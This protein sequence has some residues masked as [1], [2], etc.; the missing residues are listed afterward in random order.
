MKVVKI[1]LDKQTYQVDLKK[2]E[3]AINSN[4][5]C[6]VG[7]MPNFPHGVFDD[8]EGLSKLA[9]KYKVPLHVDACLGG[10]LVCFMKSA[11]ISIPKFDFNLPGVTSI[12]A[13]L[14][15]YGLCPKGISL[16]LYS[17]KEYR[18]HQ[19]YFYPHFMGGLYPTPS[20]EG[21]RT[22]AFIA[23]AYAVMVHVGKDAYINQAKVIHKAI[24]EIKNYANKNFKDIR[25]IGDPQICGIAFTGPKV[26]YVYEEMVGK[27]WHLN[28]I[29]NPMGFS[30]V[31]TSANLPNVPN[32]IKD[33]HDSYNAVSYMFNILG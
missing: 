11:N 28:L 5:V 22:P 32:F 10:F 15:K 18:K 3:R 4:T 27:H 23:A 25:V 1:P 20:F 13:D 14:H 16:L 9:V 8:I 24:C 2:V 33:L 7:S 30:F 12:S 17:S 6:I 21:S 26:A 19:Y 29:N 31:V